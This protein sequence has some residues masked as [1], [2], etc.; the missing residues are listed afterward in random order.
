M[1]GFLLSMLTC[2]L[3][4]RDWE[5]HVTDGENKSQS[6]SRSL[7]VVEPGFG[8]DSK[9]N[10]LNLYPQLTQDKIFLSDLLR[11]F[12]SLW[13]FADLFLFLQMEISLPCFLFLLNLKMIH[14]TRCYSHHWHP[15]PQRMRAET[16]CYTTVP[17]FQGWLPLAEGA[18][19]RSE[20]LMPP[21]YVRVAEAFASPF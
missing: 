6:L 12:I 19:D 3:W 7:N 16:S 13:P 5:S 18:P 1:E 9:A 20:C 14:A 2:K 15:S 11:C 10:T 4:G 21:E 8:P 17:N